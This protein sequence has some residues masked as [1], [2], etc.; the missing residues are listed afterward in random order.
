MKKIAI[1]LLV[2][3]LCGFSKEVYY[4]DEQ[5]GKEGLER[6]KNAYTIG[7]AA[8]EKRPIILGEVAG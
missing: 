5:K 4:N 2:F 7:D 6:L 3:L 1:F 8:P